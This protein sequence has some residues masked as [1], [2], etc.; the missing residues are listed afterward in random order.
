MAKET[1]P[2]VQVK[3]PIGMSYSDWT[4][5]NQTYPAPGH[6]DWKHVG[7]VNVQG[8]KWKGDTTIS[9]SGDPTTNKPASLGINTGANHDANVL[10]LGTGVNCTERQVR[11]IYFRTYTNGAKFRPRIS[12]VALRY[13]APNGAIYYQGLHYRSN[14]YEHSSGGSLN[15]EGTDSSHEW[16]GVAKSGT[17]DGNNFHQ[18][19]VLQG[20]LFHMETTWK[21][22]ASVWNY[23]YVWNLRFIC[24]SKRESNPNYNNQ[25]RVWGW[26]AK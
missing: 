25:Y 15:Y 16:W 8:T 3:D 20:V 18:D 24:D 1:F 9:A 7:D 12:G 5:T 17:N 4:N 23:C 14:G 26:S 21:S 2:L 11:G 10:W 19:K 22:G 13:M 6:M